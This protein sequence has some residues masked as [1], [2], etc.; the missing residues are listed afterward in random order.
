MITFDFQKLEL[1]PGYRVLDAGCGPGRHLAEAFRRQGVDVVGLD[2]K[3]ND[4]TTARNTLNL[5][6]NEKEDG[7]GH[8]LVM[9]G[10]ITGLPFADNS[11]DLVICSEVMEHIPEHERAAAEITRVLK[12][13]KA[14]V[15]S[16][17]RYLPERICW[18]LSEDYHTEEGGHVRIYRKRQLIRLLEGQGLH[19]ED[20]GRAHALHSPYWWIRCAV[21][22]VGGQNDNHWAVQ[23]YHKFLVWDIMKKPWFTRTLDKIL[24]PLISKSIV[25]YL[26]KG[27]QYGT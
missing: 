4:L 6:R 16:V 22:A 9:K 15:V 27:T 5:M 18:A 23:T 11:F 21:G 8:T 26:R 19:C 20:T 14:M 3:M 13:G 17:P 10:D 1:R 12:P 7:G 2:M 24:N 25:L